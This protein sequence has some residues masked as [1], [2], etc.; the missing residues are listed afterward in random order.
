M[1]EITLKVPEE[2][3]KFI[4]EL[5]RNLGLEV[6]SETEIPEWQKNIVRERVEEYK[7]NPDMA[8]PWKEVRKSL[9]FGDEE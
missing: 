8:I 6:K 1:K 7:K 2:K 3:Y 5:I 4:M 9:D